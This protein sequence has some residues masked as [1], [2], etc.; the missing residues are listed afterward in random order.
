MK[1]V[2]FLEPL[3]MPQVE[4]KEIIEKNLAEELNASQ[5]EIDYYDD[6]QTDP[7]VLIER[8]AGADAVVLSNFPF[9]A[10]VIKACPDLEY[11]NVAFTGYDHVD[12]KQAGS[13]NIQVSNCRGYSTVAVAEL[14]IGY[15]LSFFRKLIPAD[16]AVREGK[17]SQGFM[18]GELHGKTFGIIGL[19]DIGSQVAELAQAFGCKVIAYNRSPREAKGVDL[20]PLDEVLAKSDIVS[21][22]LPSN[23]ET[24]Q[25]I[26]AEKIALLQK[27]ALFINLA[28]G[29]IVDSEAL[30]AALNEERIA[31][32]YIDVFEME[33][34][35]P[36][37][38]P[39]LQAKNCYVTPH[40]G[41]LTQE[42]MYRRAEIVA[43]NLKGYLAG[44]PKNLVE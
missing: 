18:G 36:K 37:E 16:Q 11:I 42:S 29:P 15:A 4:L 25:L 26:N 10:E 8:C 17:T 3:G 39:L 38:H 33:P 19:G 7:E 28:R 13:Q 6:R 22:H 23:G 21:L 9:P 27:H 5:V 41:F 40:V 35:I 44:K 1:K 14:V 43:E 32:A 24:K 2:H 20:L 34:P 30:A 12:M 31:G